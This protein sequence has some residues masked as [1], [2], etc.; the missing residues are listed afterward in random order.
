VAARI[1]FELDG[2]EVTHDLAGDRAT[3]GRHASNDVV[4][5][6]PWISRRHAELYRDG[7]RWR[8]KDLGSLNG[9]QINQSGHTSAP[10]ADGDR[11]F[12]YKFPVTFRVDGPE[13]DD[14]FSRVS[15]TPTAGGQADT[16]LHTVVQ[17]AVDFSA[18]AARQQDVRRFQ[19][20]LRIVTR[21]S[22]GIVAGASSE[23]TFRN[24]LDLV[25]EHLPVE[26]GLI[27]VWDPARK[28]LDP[29]CVK[30]RGGG[31][32]SPST[33]R[34][35]ST[36]AEQVMR[37]KVAV[38][39]ADAQADERFEKGESIAE[40]GIRSAVAAPLWNGDKVE[41]LIYV[42]TTRREAFDRFDLDLLSA[43][44]NHVAV[45]LEQSRLQSSLMQQRLMRRKLERYHSPAV[46]D[47]IT[48][49]AQTLDGAMVAEEREV[50]VLFADVVG[51]T[52]RCESMEP[53]EIADLLNRYFSAMTEAV[54][55]HQG[56]VDKFIGDCIMAVFGA[57]VPAEDHAAQAVAAAL[58]MREALERLNA[59]LP[60]ESRVQVRI[61]LHSGPV[62]AGDIGSKHRTDY[63]VLGATVNL[64][65]RLETM[66]AGPDQ[67]VVS[68]VTLRAAGD[69]F[70]ARPLGER[71]LRGISDPVRCYEIVA[72]R[73]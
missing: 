18:L 21:A 10:L 32:G 52:R 34:F 68:D 4:I 67:I 31:G 15:L 3:I 35:S 61:A 44:G 62:V 58:E 23:D 64:A 72:P 29:R 26:R 30:E 73:A 17:D 70:D 57:P 47:Y 27:M 25:F 41:G 33:I 60:P 28:K 36:I 9:T 69:R 45:A 71:E 6:H 16:R 40:L 42:D 63:T 51:F 14:A 13:G 48:S 38:L 12:L 55:R 24:V 53:R 11:V 49:T 66:V 37:E 7:D 54:F 43:L 2:R 1:V 39:T 8:V 46:I 19:R 65:A 20:L 22:A 5:D 59:P 56:T 50:T